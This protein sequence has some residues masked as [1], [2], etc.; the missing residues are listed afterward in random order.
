MTASK[1]FRLVRSSQATVQ[2]KSTV[3]TENKDRGS[4]NSKMGPSVTERVAESKNS[5]AFSVGGSASVGRRRLTQEEVDEQRL[6]GLCFTCNEPFNRNH[7]C[8]KKQLY[9]LIVETGED[10]VLDSEALLSEL[11]RKREETGVS[12]YAL[13]GEVGGDGIRTMKV[14]GNY[15]KRSLHILVDSGSTH[16]FLDSRIIGGINVVIKPII[17]VTMAVAD[18]RSV[19]CNRMI[20]QF[21]WA[22]QGMEFQVD[23]YVL[24][25]GGCEIILGV[26]WL[27]Q[28]GD[29][30]W[31]F[32][33]STMRFW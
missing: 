9:S 16:N 7:K 22:I 8:S 6:K 28:L 33:L 32:K 17:P 15:K 27:S 26:D 1:P 29:I 3:F 4:I 25:L 2:G 14:R 13:N 30:T 10:S 12:I 20:P 18:G 24:A 11:D 21:T 19:L 5:F 23:F 31:N